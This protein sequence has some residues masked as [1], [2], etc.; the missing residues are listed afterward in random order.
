MYEP[1]RPETVCAHCRHRMV[2]ELRVIRNL[3]A[4]PEVVDEIRT[5]VVFDFVCGHCHRTRRE[6]HPLL[7][8]HPRHLPV[9]IF[10]PPPGMSRHDSQWTGTELAQI[11]RAAEAM[12]E[13]THV[14][15]GE[16]DA[17]APLLESWVA[18]PGPAD[19]RPGPADEPLP[20]DLGSL[21]AR[22]RARL[23]PGAPI[24]D[25]LAQ[26]DTSLAELRRARA[27]F[28]RPA[29]R[30]RLANVL[31]MLVEL[32]ISVELN[33]IEEL[34][35]PERG[36]TPA[37]Y[38]RALELASELADRAEG[39][40]RAHASVYQGLAL[41]KL[42]R[43]RTAEAIAV[44]EAVLP[45]LRAEAE[46][47]WLATALSNLAA[48][49]CD[50]PRDGARATWIERAIA[51]GEEALALPE[52]S[53]V[54]SSR[55]RARRASV[56][57]NLSNAYGSRVAG[58]PAANE[59]HSRQ[60]AERALEL[61]DPV[62]HPNTVA[63]IRNNI[64]THYLRTATGD[65]FANL[66]KARAALESAADGLRR[67]QAPVEWAVIQTSLGLCHALRY[68]G[69]RDRN[70]EKAFTHFSNAV[71]VLRRQDGRAEWAQARIGLATTMLERD[72]EPADRFEQ[73]A[74][75][76]LA[77]VL[78]VVSDDPDGGVAAECH[79]Q[80]AMLFTRKV[81]QGAVE[82]ADQAM[83]HNVRA[84]SYY[85]RERDPRSWGV[86]RS[87]LSLILAKKAEP[88]RAGALAAAG[89]AIDTLRR[90]R[91]PFE[92]GIAQLNKAVVH[93][94]GGELEDAVHHGEL[95]LAE[96]RPDRTPSV[97]VRVASLLGE[98]HAAA[99]RWPAAAGAFRQAV[100]AWR[101]A[102]EESVRT[103]ARTGLFRQAGVQ[104]TS[105]AYAAAR[106]GD[107]E[108]A[109]V[110]A[111]A[112][113][114]FALREALELDPAT[115]EPA[116][117]RTT[118]EYETYLRALETM[119]AAEAA[120]R[121]PWL[122]HARTAAAQ[123]R[124][125][126]ER[127]QAE[128]ADARRAAADARGRLTAR[129][130]TDV[131]AIRRYAAGADALVY[132]LSTSWGSVLLTLRPET[133]EMTRREHDLRHEDLSELLFHGGGGLLVGAVFGDDLIRE[134]LAELRRSPVADWLRA[135]LAAAGAGAG[136][137]IV[138]PMGPW[139][140]VP[141]GLFT[142]GTLVQ[143]VSAEVRHHCR[144]RLAGGAGRR[145]GVLAYADPSLPLAGREV[146]E[147]SAGVVVPPGPRAKAELL[148]ALPRF[149]H[150][151]LATHGVYAP[152]EPADSAIRI[153]S[154]ALLLREL[155]ERQLLSGVRLVFLSACQTGISDVLSARDEVVGLPSACIYSGAIGVIGTLWP[156][157]DAATFLFVRAFY[158]AAAEV[159]PP[160]A[161]ARARRRLRD[162]TAGEI[163][164][165]CVDLP[166]A[167]SFLRFRPPSD[168]PFRDPFFWA[169][170]IYV[171]A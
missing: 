22:I 70:I 108:Q 71:S 122:A 137:T 14:V 47:T 29:D 92:W 36:A 105:A 139:S 130:P 157:D 51:A 112:G 150:L 52:L 110:L 57:A 62:E 102:Y 8:Y 148:A 94:L 136:S 33:R 171:G 167:L 25:R 126:D 77:E 134:A 132:V 78:A 24:A 75:E 151:H 169:P 27:R 53:R 65:R 42:D 116:V 72:R 5:G 50:Q 89:E 124:L 1:L 95:A 41:F 128:L 13:P 117:D 81:N 147:L 56:L 153:G 133:G 46:R 64:G 80:L 135:G 131:T 90:D 67:A 48:M 19:E 160:A 146:A 125:D 30:Q 6:P 79:Q 119:R 61:L 12:A 58:D 66:E 141:F 23:D 163:L 83:E 114:A 152:A 165:E 145:P 43:G 101:Y 45:V 170:F 2:L 158:R 106:A 55:D 54:D 129:K 156:V 31:P 76:L 17:V 162:V 84:G 138:V 93:Q 123:A 40:Q 164:R 20:D 154:D 15:W 44:V 68:G 10:V 4:E 109:I 104:H 96:L 107:L 11:V 142:D 149:T 168:R 98:C 121:A 155:I 127:R 100:D 159:E 59:V 87:G 140:A 166:P 28:G 143:A 86:L 26:I 118:P 37:G 113:R 91:F 144:T 120:V 38:E 39:S 115:V 18:H 99:G 85:D 7:V 74:I 32:R 161:L 69:N 103:S 63:L 16:L 34:I 21:L 82:H 49:Y 111:E 35:D 88:D 97:A 73:Q 3:E 9:M 60:L